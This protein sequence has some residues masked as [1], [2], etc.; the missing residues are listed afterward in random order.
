MAAV[1]ALLF[2]FHLVAGVLGGLLILIMSATGVLL[3]FQPQILEWLERD[4]RRIVA[5]AGGQRLAPSALLAAGTQGR[6][7]S[8][9]GTLTLSRDPNLSAVVSFGREG[10][11]YVNPYTGALLGE[12]AGRARAWFQWLIEFHR[13]LAVQPADRPLVR[14]ATGGSSILFACLALTGVVLWW[15]RRVSLASLVRAATPRWAGTAAARE[16]NWHTVIGFWCAPVIVVLALS[17]AVLSFPWANRLLHAAAG[18][19]LPAPQATAPRTAAAGGAAAERQGARVPVDYAGV[20]PIWRLAEQQ[21][22]SWGTIAMRI[23]ARLEGPVSFTITDAAHWNK[24][25]RSQLTVNMG[26]GA[27]VRWE[28]YAQQTRGQHWRGWARFAHTGELGGLT[29]QVVAAAASAGGVMLVWTGMSLA[30]RRLAR[31]RARRPPVV[32]R[33]A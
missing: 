10:I 9:Q 12:G 21:M 3:A 11:R 16:F 25:A 6:T 29:G 7:G 18:T 4:Q 19:P 20:D 23:P 14:M 30:L 2:W 17:G 22:P 1:R 27:V 32:A 13:W 26:S 5:P 33:A 8:E 28:P 31:A 15:P 24:F